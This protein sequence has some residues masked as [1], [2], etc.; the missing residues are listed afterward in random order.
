MR[1][2]LEILISIFIIILCMSINS[3]FDK[4]EQIIIIILNLNIFYLA[5]KL[6]EE[7]KNV[8]IFY[9]VSCN[10]LFNTS[11]ALT[12]YLRKEY[13]LK[14][15]FFTDYIPFDINVSEFIYD[16][17]IIN[18]IGILIGILSIYLNKK[19]INI[20]SEKRDMLQNSVLCLLYIFF[21]YIFIENINEVQ[22]VI[23]IGYVSSYRILKLK[24]FSY[25]LVTLFDFLIVI[26]LSLK[27]KFDIKAKIII[28]IYII[29][30]FISSLKGSRG[31][32]LIGL[33]FFFWY[34]EIL[35]VFKINKK[36][37][38]ILIFLISIYSN[39]I[40]S[41]RNNYGKDINFTMVKT[42][43]KI[44]EIPKK[45][46]ESQNSTARMIGYLKT[47]PEITE[48]ENNGKMIF[49]SFHTF[50]D[51]I[52]NKESVSTRKFEESLGKRASN[53]SRISYIINSK[54]VQLGYGLGGN[55]IV[56]MYEIGKK[57]G[58]LFF[59]F[60]FILMIYF[61]ENIFKKNNSIYKN[62]FVILIFKK[63]FF[64]P[65]SYY[66]DFNIREYFYIC[67]IYFVLLNYTNILKIKIGD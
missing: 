41:I 16:I 14:S 67:F 35:E 58:V 36:H 55:Y 20:N 25:Y 57:Y 5:Y 39:F 50:Y 29:L 19:K 53:F 63:I 40:R 44:I 17:L 23:S 51:S 1:R 61:L 54:Y 21:I 34:L 10:F 65:R 8:M 32:F 47:F 42:N 37:M 28:G 38:L 4:K 3:I 66:F 46:L 13:I 27:P 49:S 43:S 12:T 26:Y 62:I 15:Q 9:F 24:N 56:E 2:K 30:L 59:S 48:G 52:F 45:F 33:I 22:N 18:S 60:L 6:K 11:I 64:A 31:I 7:K